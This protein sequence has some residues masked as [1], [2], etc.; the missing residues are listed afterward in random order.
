MIS[1]APVPCSVPEFLTGF[2]L[3][4]SNPDSIEGYTGDCTLSFSGKYDGY[5]QV[6]PIVNGKKEGVSKIFTPKKVLHVMLTFTGDE[7]T[8]PLELYD[9]KGALSFQGTLKNGIRV[10]NAMEYNNGKLKQL[11]YFNQSGQS[12]VLK[13]FNGPNMTEYDDKGNRIYFGEYEDNRIANYPRNGNGTLFSNNHQQ[14]SGQWYHNCP[15][16]DGFARKNGVTIA[17]G[18][19]KRGYIRTKDG[20]LDY[21]SLEEEKVDREEELKHWNE[22]PE[23]VWKE[24]GKEKKIPLQKPGTIKW[25]LDVIIGVCCIIFLI[26]L[27]AILVIVGTRKKEVIIRSYDDLLNLSEDTAIVRVYS[28]A[29]ND[30]TFNNFVLEGYQKLEQ[31]VIEDESLS[32]I[33]YTKIASLP[34]LTHF[35]VGRNSFMGTASGNAL[36]LSITNCS[37]L[38]EVSIGAIS[39]RYYTAVELSGYQIRRALFVELPSLAKLV[40]GTSGTESFNF[41]N[42]GSFELTNLP[43]L[44]EII[45]GDSVFSEASSISFSG[46]LIWIL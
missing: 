11:L 20:F 30:D 26:A 46:C 22:R 13:L 2:V 5:T 42:I 41:E 16:G 19:W 34:V 29:C 38:Y 44:K 45:F 17:S 28:H 15:N 37:A 43:M 23:Y 9:R 33:N 25:R 10:G 18:K 36:E 7:M 21:E 1:Q 40:I 12:R 31:I 35:S 8:G 3:K 39:F 32:N 4:S 6:I 24:K 27:V 14:Y